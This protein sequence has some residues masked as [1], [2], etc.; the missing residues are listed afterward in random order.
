MY[1]L[2]ARI[3]MKSLSAEG[4][5]SKLSTSVMPQQVWKLVELSGQTRNTQ[6][7][8]HSAAVLHMFE[9]TGKVVY[10]P[11]TTALFFIWLYF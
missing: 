3:F 5:R 4:L 8:Y 7:S 9:V 10:M 1:P 6:L 11:K 2:S